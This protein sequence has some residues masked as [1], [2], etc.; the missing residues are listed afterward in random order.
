MKEDRITKTLARPEVGQGVSLRMALRGSGR[1]VS[2]MLMWSEIPNWLERKRRK[3][4]SDFCP[5][6]RSFLLN[7]LFSLNAWD[8]PGTISI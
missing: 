5:Q 4:L 1:P 7:V 8:L 3:T 2:S 6:D